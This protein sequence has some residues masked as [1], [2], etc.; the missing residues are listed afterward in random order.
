MEQNKELIRINVNK[1]KGVNIV[2]KNI[3]KIYKEIKKAIINNSNRNTLLFAILINF[4]I[5]AFSR[6]SLFSGFNYVLNDPINFINGSLIVFLTLSASNLF[7]K[8]GFV[9]GFIS[10]IWI[11]LGVANFVLLG[12]RTTPLAAIDFQILQ[13]VL[14]I[15]SVYFNLTQIIMIAIAIVLVIIG[16]GFSYIKMPKSKVHYK[17]AIVSLLLAFSLVLVVPSFSLE[18]ERSNQFPNLVDAYEKY[19]FVYCFSTSIFDRGI[20][21]PENYS[22]EA[23]IELANE[24]KENEEEVSLKPNIVMVQLESFF[25]VNYLKDISYSQNPVP[26]F[27][28]LKENY[29]SGK[30]T[31]PSIGAGTANTEFEV[32]T[33]MNLDFFGSGEYPYKT[34]LNEDTV[35]SLA[36][37]LAPLGYKS[38]AIHNNNGSF[39]DRHEVFKNLGFDSFSSIEYMYDVDFTSLGWAKDHIL[40]EEIMKDLESSEGQDFTFAISVQAHGRYPNLPISS[41]ND[42][43]IDGTIDIEKHFSFSYFINQM[44]EVDKFIGELVS[45]MEQFDEPTILVIYGDHFPSLGIYNDKLEGCNR[46]QTEYVIWSNYDTQQEE[47]DLDAYQLGSYI[48]QQVGVDNG[49]MTKHHQQKALSE[50]YQDDMKILQYDMLFGERVVFD[51]VNPYSPKD[52]KMGI[53]QIK[54]TSVKSID[55]EILVYGENFNEWST[56]YIDGDECETKYLDQNTLIVEEEIEEGSEIFVAQQSMKRIILSKTNSLYFDK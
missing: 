44:Y 13:S 33:G 36:Y 50:T 16:L 40:V 39:Y 51:G 38:H 14:G 46:F 48:L 29:S 10:T 45:E 22:K 31:V 37:N 19:G 3:K 23:V 1:F 20:E 49:V 42:I 25:D 47:K 9:F 5:E 12:F 54:L 8:K 2:N 52:L 53:D 41:D 26:N 21:E 15:I 7:R 34:V 6:K 30:L 18:E 35:E 24:Y 56:V 17:S 43:E 11:A 55:Q 32:L 28:Y 4:V 27:T